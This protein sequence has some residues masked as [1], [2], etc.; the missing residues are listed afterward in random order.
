MSQRNEIAALHALTSQYKRRLASAKQIIQQAHDLGLP[1]YMSL[2]G[3]KDSTIVYSLVRQVQ[4]EIPAVWSGSRLQRVSD[5]Y[6]DP[7]Y[8][9]V[10]L[11]GRAQRLTALYPT[12][13]LAVVLL[14]SA[15]GGKQ[16]TPDAPAHLWPI[17][18][19]SRGSILALQ[20]NPRLDMAG[21][22]GLHRLY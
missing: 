17:V 12:K 21:C 8:R 7:A 1:A 10:C 11:S 15:P 20:S 6:P 18:L 3:G 5:T 14:G 2:S 16:Y 13:W 4:P 22:V 19:R 9:V